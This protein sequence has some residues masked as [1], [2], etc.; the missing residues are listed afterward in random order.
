MRRTKNLQLKFIS[1]GTTPENHAI[2]RQAAKLGGQS[3]GDFMAVSVI[4]AAKSVLAAQ[5]VGVLSSPTVPAAPSSPDK[6]DRLVEAIEK[7]LRSPED[8]P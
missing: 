4:A 6:V 3:L 2:I 5:P 8:D 7:F 1:T